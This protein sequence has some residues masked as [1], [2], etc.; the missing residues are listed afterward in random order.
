MLSV[1]L[2]TGVADVELPSGLTTLLDISDASLGE[3]RN[4]T[5]AYDPSGHF[6][7]LEVEEVEVSLLG[8]V[9]TCGK[10]LST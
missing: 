4:S 2:P 9:C 8:S 5:S 10:L 7:G 6:D 1:E 3:P